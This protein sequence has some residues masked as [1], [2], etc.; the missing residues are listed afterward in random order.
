VLWLTGL[1]RPDYYY[2]L[3][4]MGDDFNHSAINFMK[5]A[6]TYSNF[7]TTVS[8]S[9]AWEVRYTDWG[10][11]LGHILHVNQ[12][13]FSGVLNG[14]DYEMWNPATDS[15]IDHHYDV[16]HVESKYENK[17]ALRGRL[18][19]ADEFKP[20]VAYVGRLDTQKGVH[21]IRHALF[22]SLQRGAQFVLLGS[23]PELGINA[24]FWQLKHELNDNPNCHLEIGY[25]EELAHLIYA[26]ADMLVV[27]SMFEPCG[28]TQ[29]IALR[30]GAVPIVR[31]VGGLKD[32]IFDVDYSD[33]PADKRNGYV[34]YEADHPALESA[35]NRALELWF[36]HPKKFLQLIKN[37][38]SW[39]YSWNKPGQD[40]MNIYEYIRHK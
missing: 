16:D 12:N 2:Q 3:D 39:D 28:L 29:M 20:I 22:Y 6:V 19:L 35:M 24:E 9:H 5:G 18:L 1:G 25:D 40:Y 33:Q 15:Y 30:Y 13:K 7:I 38:M 32:T 10:Y 21:L 27:P 8:P 34:F 37:G 11:G 23:S 17:S 4:R 36:E 14:L 26:G 31:A